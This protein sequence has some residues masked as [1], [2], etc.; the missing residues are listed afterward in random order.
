[1]LSLVSYATA[2][3]IGIII[4]FIKFNHK[5]QCLIEKLE[6]ALVSGISNFGFVVDCTRLL[7]LF[8]NGFMI[9]VTNIETLIDH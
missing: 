7:L 4:I 3:N 2:L 5:L 6:L 1:M 9:T 8:G